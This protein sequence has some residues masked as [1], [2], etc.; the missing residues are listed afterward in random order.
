LVYK[1]RQE[2]SICPS[3][4]PHVPSVVWCVIN[5]G[6]EG[7]VALLKLNLNRSKVE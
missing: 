7:E 4:H 5:Q 3:S 1:T 2:P 6:D